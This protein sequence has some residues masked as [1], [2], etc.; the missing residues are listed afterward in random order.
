MRI[1]YHP[2]KLLLGGYGMLYNWYCTQQQ[3][4]VEYGY[5]YN[6]YAATDAR[7]ISSVGWHVPTNS[8][9]ATLETTLGGST[10]AGGHLKQIGISHW[11]SPNSSADNSSGFSF[12]GT[13]YRLYN[14]TF[15]GLNDNGY[16]WSSDSYDTND[17]RYLAA[18]Y[19]TSSSSKW[20]ENKKSG[21]AIRPIKD[22]TT[23]T[24][25][26]TGTYVDPSGII[27]PT[28]CIGTQ[29]WVACNI[30]TKHYRNGDAIPEV[31]DNTAWAALTTGARC[32]YNNTES[33]AG[34]IKKISSSNEW[35][36]PTLSEILSLVSFVGGNML[37]GGKLKETGFIHW[38]S[39][40]T[41]ATD[42][43]HFGFVGSG[44]R[45]YTGFG[46]DINY[47]GTL[48]SRDTLGDNAAYFLRT[49]YNSAELPNDPATNNT[50]YYNGF[51]IRLCNPNTL[52]AEGSVNSYTQNDGTVI[53]TIVINGVEWT[54]NLKET[55]WS[56]GSNIQNITDNTAWSLLQSAACCDI[57]NDPTKR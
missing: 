50:D 24:N 51:S 13:G 12:V 47:D 9:F 2:R 7:N 6:W 39:P 41:G 29:E 11:R 55:K 37:A 42:D 3:P 34:S 15:N 25:G 10:T 52:N 31:T 45:G 5:L 1:L 28:I 4:S 35:D 20:H 18:F 30:M 57:N 33:N 56:D 21:F 49:T 26:Q 27:Y 32:S 44:S 23:L 36:V 40:N 43:Y 19:G 22:S 14:G 8:E 48:W 53:P 17:G 46:E 54:M 38:L 16:C